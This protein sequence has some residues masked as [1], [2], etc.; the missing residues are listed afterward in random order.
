MTRNEITLLN[1]LITAAYRWQGPMRD[2]HTLCKAVIVALPALEEL[3]KLSRT[4]AREKRSKGSIPVEIA[5]L[6]EAVA[7]L[8]RQV[9][10][11]RGDYD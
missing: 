10:M 2:D 8:Q 6:Q 3:L 4:R 1:G 7:K 5:Q 9:A 11:L